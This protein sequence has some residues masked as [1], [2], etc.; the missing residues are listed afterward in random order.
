M[1]WK[2]ERERERIK[3]KERDREGG[4]ERRESPLEGEILDSLH[5]YLQSFRQFQWEGERRQQLGCC[6][7]PA[8]QWAHCQRDGEPA[9][10]QQQW[11]LYK[12]L[13]VTMYYR[14]REGEGER[15]RERD[16]GRERE[17]EGERERERGR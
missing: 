14:G 12:I 3:E 15:E 9:Y 1:E 16:G 4:K 7:S 5:P 6:S 8:W 10:D 17:R 11:Q 13:N 2:R